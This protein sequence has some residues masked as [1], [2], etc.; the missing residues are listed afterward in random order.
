[1]SDPL[2]SGSDL[3]SNEDK[4]WPNRRWQ[5]PLDPKSRS[6]KNPIRFSPNMDKT[7]KCV[8]CHWWTW[9]MFRHPARTINIDSFYCT[10][11]RYKWTI[12]QSKQFFGAFLK[13]RDSPSYHP[14]FSLGFSMGKP[15]EN[16]WGQFG[17]PAFSNEKANFR[18]VATGGLL[19]GFSSGW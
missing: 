19:S 17:H 9:C 13:N 6:D 10:N 3:Q 2:A 8:Q 1:M 15:S 7:T 16:S 11:L 12:I 14:H 5:R 4:T 18:T